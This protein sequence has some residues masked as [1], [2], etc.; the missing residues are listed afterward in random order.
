MPILN[1]MNDTSYESFDPIRRL[2][3]PLLS[4]FLSQPKYYMPEKETAETRQKFELKTLLEPFLLMPKYLG[5]SSRQVFYTTANEALDYDFGET[6]KLAIRSRNEWFMRQSTAQL[7]AIAAAHPA[8]LGFNKEN[9]GVFRET[10]VKCCPLPN[11]MISILDAW[12]ALHG[13]KTRFPS[14][15]KRAFEDR[16]KELTPYHAGKYT[17]TSIDSTRICHIRRAKQNVDVIPELMETGSVVLDDEDTTWEK[18]RSMG[19]SWPETFEAMGCRVPHMAALRNL[20]SVARSDPGEEFMR[21]WCNM[22]ISGVKGGKQFPFRYISAKTQMEKSINKGSKNQDGDD[23]HDDNQ[24]GEDQHY[25]SQKKPKRTIKPIHDKYRPI[26]W[27]C[28]ERCLQVSIENFPKLEGSVIALSDNSGS[29]HGTFTSTYGKHTVADIGNLSALITAMSCTGRGVVGIFGDEL[30]LYEVSKTK[31]IL[32]QYNEIN[33]LGERVGQATEN[34]VWLFFKRAF[35]NPVENTFDYFF[36]YSDMQVGHGGL[37]GNDPE[38]MKGGWDWKKS[39]GQNIFINIHTLFDTY[40]K[41]IHPK[42]NAFMVQTAGYTDTILPESI[43]R[44]AIMA[45]WTGNEVIYAKEY[46]KLWDEMEGTTME[47]TTM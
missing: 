39:Y 25:D 47:G 4:G 19:K 23:Q 31:P 1:F 6:L 5:M 21:R 11:D 40:R 2:M 33:K 8:R 10:I 29:A 41:N 35:Q 14:F 3:M 44:G 18:H 26:I 30:F 20:C 28:L 46:T 32:E 13:S 15:V 22:V 38:I 34:G 43:Y 37:Y 36:C 17:K 7:L 16:L 27:D 24:D 42:I 45:G 12:K 9:P